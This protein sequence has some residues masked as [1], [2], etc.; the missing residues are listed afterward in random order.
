VSSASL[1]MCGLQTSCGARQDDLQIEGYEARPNE[2]VMFLVN[3]VTPTYFSTLG[4]PLLAGRTFSDRDGEHAPKVAVVNRTL[5]AKYF[6][7]GQGIG[8]R[9]GRTTNDVEIVGIVDDARL[10]SVREAAIPTAYFPIAQRPAATRALEVRSTGDPQLIIGAVRTA[11]A[12][13]APDMIIDS[14][15]PMEERISV[16]L[17]QDRLI[18]FLASG[19]GVLAL[20]LAGFGL[21]GLLSYAVAR[22]SSE[23]GIRMALGASR[24]EVQWSVV[25]EALWLVLCGLL[26][27]APFVMAGGRLVSALVFGISPHDWATFFGAAIVLAAVASA[28]SLLPA[29]R[30]SRVDPLVALRQE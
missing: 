4:T 1:A 5:A 23:F 9:F 14:I 28:C 15:V 26:L 3:S 17:S 25:R 11:V 30:A 8:R 2:R 18:V 20:G 6:E 27:G 22:R 12:R 16:N 21:F 7:K 13:A 19:F 10:L 29:R 24:A